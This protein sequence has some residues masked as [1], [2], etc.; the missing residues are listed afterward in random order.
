MSWAQS[1]TTLICLLCKMYV[2]C[3]YQKYW[4]FAPLSRVKVRG[5]M[6]G[7]YKEE[8]IPPSFSNNDKVLYK[9]D[10]LEEATQ[11]LR[12]MQRLNGTD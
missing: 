8:E 7:V 5:L 11:Y 3:L 9:W 6:M 4:K 10:S 2:I 1:L 12:E